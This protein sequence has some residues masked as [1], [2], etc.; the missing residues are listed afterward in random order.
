L[1]NSD[2][3]DAGY[4]NIKRQI[5]AMHIHGPKIQEAIEVNPNS[6]NKAIKFVLSN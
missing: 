5:L 4:L 6:E 1:N 3:L 2:Y